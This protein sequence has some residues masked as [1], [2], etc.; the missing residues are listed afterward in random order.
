M[1]EAAKKQE[2]ETLVELLHKSDAR[3]E[4]AEMKVVSYEAALKDR[5]STISKLQAKLDKRSIWDGLRQFTVESLGFPWSIL[6]AAIVIFVGKMAFHWVQTPPTPPEPARCYA[7]YE[8]RAI[9]RADGVETDLEVV[10][11]YWLK[12][13]YR[14]EKLILG[15]YP[16]LDA[17]A[18]QA[19]KLNC[20]I[21]K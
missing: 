16:T 15:E 21:D 20:P 1:A 7:V 14:G 4:Q 18:E 19:R 17:A 9:L 13:V 11:K 12:K 2:E 10:P 5:E 8:K 6:V 3:A